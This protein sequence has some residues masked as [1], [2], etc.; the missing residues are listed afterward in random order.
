MALVRSLTRDDRSS[1]RPHPTEVD[2]RWQVI[3]GRKGVALFQLSTYGSDGRA[4]DPK[5]S[6]T[7]QLDR[8]MAAKLVARLCETFD[9]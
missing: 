8:D 4:S 9:L 1:G 2:C 7:I 6:Q 3:N 5:V